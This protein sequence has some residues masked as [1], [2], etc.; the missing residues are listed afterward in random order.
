MTFWIAKTTKIP[1][2]VD[3]ALHEDPGAAILAVDPLIFI[4]QT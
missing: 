1:E 3:F 4:L 2:T